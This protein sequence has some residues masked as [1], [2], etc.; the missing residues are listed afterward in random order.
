M[1]HIIYSIVM[2]KVAQLRMSFYPLRGQCV[3]IGRRT[4]NTSRFLTTWAV[5]LL[6]FI[7]LNRLTR[8]SE[9]I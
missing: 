4:R 2:Q 3:F 6:L 1:I 9:W 8:L 5:I 7:L